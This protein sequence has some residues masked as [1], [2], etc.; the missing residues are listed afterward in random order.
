M[1]EE[2]GI[3]GGN[4]WQS[5]TEFV[6]S[7]NK[8]KSNIQQ[9]A[10]H[11]TSNSACF[12]TSSAL[13]LKS[14]IQ[15][16]AYHLTSNSACFCTS[17]A[18]ILKSNIQQNAYHLTSNSAC[19]CTSSALILKSNI[20]QNA[21]HLT[22]NSACFC[23][24]S[25]LI[26]KS[27]I[28]QNAYHLT[29]NSA[30]FCTSSALI[31]FNIKSASF[32]TLTM[33]SRVAWANN[34]EN[35]WTVLQKRDINTVWLRIL[36]TLEKAADMALCLKLPL[37]QYIYTSHAMRKCVFGSLRPGK[38]QTDLLSYR[39]QLES[40]NFGYINYRYYSVLAANNKGA[41]QTTRMHRLICTFVVRIWHKT[42]FL[43]A[44]LICIMHVRNWQMWNTFSSHDLTVQ[45]SC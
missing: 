21:Y 44:W 25:A 23:T 15:Q 38:T 6:F 22:S 31:L 5:R 32:A 39:D 45:L 34:L 1:V 20:Q 40:Q 11:L 41:D 26:L 36:Q 18:L 7:S 43:M 2:T 12:C 16:N 29:S 28:Q 10:Y 19:F 30:C 33:W 42:H 9:N 3:P 8:Q 17:S 35:K 14:N 4:H 24:S 37:V 13:I 27:N